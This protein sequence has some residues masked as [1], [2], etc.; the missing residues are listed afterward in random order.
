MILCVCVNV[1]AIVLSH[2]LIQNEWDERAI[3]RSAGMGQKR[4]WQ[5]ATEPNEIIMYIPEVD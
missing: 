5:K 1:R 2:M 4:D 3:F